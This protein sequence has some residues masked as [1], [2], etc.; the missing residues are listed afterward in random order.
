MALIAPPIGDWSKKVKNQFNRSP[1][2]LNTKIKTGLKHIGKRSGKTL[3]M[4]SAKRLSRLYP[5]QNGVV[6]AKCTIG[7]GNSSSSFLD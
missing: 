2:S 1:L 5:R 3:A 6:V 7:L 4:N